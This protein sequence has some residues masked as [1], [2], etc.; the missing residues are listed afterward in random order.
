MEGRCSDAQEERVSYPLIWKQSG[1]ST[2]TEASHL[3]YSG[4]IRALGTTDLYDENDGKEVWT[5]TALPSLPSYG[6]ISAALTDLSGAILSTL[7][8]FSQQG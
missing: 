2:Y 3:G 6:V 8:A 1:V 7:Q 4:V 5:D